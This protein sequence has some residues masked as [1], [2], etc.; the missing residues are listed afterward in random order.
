MSAW[1]CRRTV[2][3]PMYTRG[4]RGKHYRTGYLL[5]KRRKH[6][7]QAVLP[8]F[9]V[10]VDCVFSSRQ[11]VHIQRFDNSGGAHDKN[12]ALGYRVERAREITTLIKT[13]NLQYV[14]FYKSK[15]W[16]IFYF[17]SVSMLFCFYLPH[18]QIKNNRL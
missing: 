18:N 10:V 17:R 11:P 15:Y 2:I 1:H 5:G 9:S 6:T 16:T 7:V 14:F 12:G 8:M 13:Q 3:R 4:Y